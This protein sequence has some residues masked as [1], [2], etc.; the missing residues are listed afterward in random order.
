MYS[1]ILVAL[2]GSKLSERI[3]PYARLFAERLKIPVGLL[4]VIDPETLTAAKTDSDAY[5]ETLLAER[6][7]T[8]A[9]YLKNI[10]G[11]FPG[12]LTVDCAVEV[13]KPAE[14]IVDRAADNAGTLVAIGTHGR[15]GIQRWLVGSVADKV[16][17]VARNPLLLVRTME[18]AKSVETLRL[19][20]ILVPLDGSA[21]AES[22]IP[23]AAELSR[24]MDLEI[25]LVRIFNLPTTYYDEGYVADERVW[26]LI[27]DEA[28]EYLD[29]KVKELKSEGLAR[30]TSVLLEGFAGERIINLARETPENLIAICTHGRS[31]VRRFVLGSIADRVVRHS[32][33][34]VLVIR[35][36]GAP[37]GT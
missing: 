22:V 10:A 3:L 11:T 12:G 4:G 17:Q 23:Y 19:K 9:Y 15:S 29:R 36:P 31:G 2:D 5:R 8:A 26:E 37:F 7:K 35:A 16:L 34:P 1:K 27:R 33:D 13:G 25:V 32:G 14:A 28:Q 6:K 18:E 20:S 21:L 30:V 24:K